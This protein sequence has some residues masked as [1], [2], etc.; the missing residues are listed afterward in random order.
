[1]L[2]HVVLVGRIS[3][4]QS[5]YE[6]GKEKRNVILAIQR[7]FKNSDGIY[8]TDFI[9]CALWSNDY[10]PLEFCKVGD[11]IGIKGYLTTKDNELIV[12]S[13]RVTFLN[14]SKTN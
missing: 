3:N 6:N 5:D 2:N 9:K 8:E 1:M 4:L 11:L 14:S 13:T 12:Q 10:N 7:A